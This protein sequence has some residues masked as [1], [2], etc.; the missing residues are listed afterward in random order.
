M[1]RVAPEPDR[2]RD[3]A[4]NDREL[5]AVI[6][7]ARQMP[8]PFSAI[9]EVLVL[10][11]QRREKVAQMTWR[12]RHGADW[13]H[14]DPPPVRYRTMKTFLPLGVTLTPKPGRPAS[15]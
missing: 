1:L 9:L 3:R 8:A 12:R 10:T 15:Q 14:E 7:A 5:G 4:L 11:G 2:V 6:L 13:S